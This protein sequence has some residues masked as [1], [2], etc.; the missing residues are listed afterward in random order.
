MNIPKLAKG[1]MINNQLPII[2]ERKGKNLFRDKY[3]EIYKRTKNRRIKK[4]QLK[5]SWTL[6]MQN[7]MKPFIDEMNKVE[8]ITLH[9]GNKVIVKKIGDK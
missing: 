2:G 8:E 6:K 4:K 3:Y 5:K 1:G 9:I 7:A